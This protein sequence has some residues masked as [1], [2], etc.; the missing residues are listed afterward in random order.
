MISD[1]QGVFVSG[2]LISNNVIIAHNLVHA[3]RTNAATSKEFMA[4]KIDMSKA[5]ERVEWKLEKLMKKLGFNLQWVKWIMYC[6][7]LVIYDVLIN[8][9]PMD[10]SNQ[11]GRSG[12]G[13]LYPFFYSY[14]VLKLL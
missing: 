7:S 2:R 10:S 3:L 1:T 11:N 8:D 4:V 12:R 13:I 14:Y 9:N 5:Y 6:V